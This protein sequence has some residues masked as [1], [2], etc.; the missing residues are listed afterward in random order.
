MC[1]IDAPIGVSSWCMEAPMEPAPSGAPVA[2]AHRVLTSI[3]LRHGVV[4]TRSALG[5][6]SYFAMLKVSGSF[7]P[8]TPRHPSE[9]SRLGWPDD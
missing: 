2:R 6:S 9:K 3:I 1:G 7:D 4:V 8:S 5:F